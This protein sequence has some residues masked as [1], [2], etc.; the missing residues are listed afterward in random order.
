MRCESEEGGKVL[1]HIIT[2]SLPYP[3][4]KLAYKVCGGFQ[5]DKERG[6]V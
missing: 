5:Q 1:D 3:Y 2:S 6:P 4:K